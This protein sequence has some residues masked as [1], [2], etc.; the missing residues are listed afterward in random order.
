MRTVVDFH[1]HSKYARATSP[2]LGVEGLAYGAKLKGIDVIGTGDFTHPLWLKELKSKLNDLK[3]GL[4]EYD[5]AKFML[6][7]EVN[8]VFKQGE[9]VRKIHTVIAVSSFSEAEAINEELSKYGDLKA[10]GRPTLNMT[11]EEMLEKVMEVSDAFIVPAHVWTPWFSTF[12]SRFG[13]NSVKEI[14][15]SSEKYI[16][17][18]ETGLSSDPAMNWMISDLDKYSLVSNSDAHSIDKLGREANVFDLQEVSFSSIVDAV[19]TRKGFVKT[20]EFYPH[21]GK[22]YYDGHRKCNI[23]LSPE[24]S[25]QYNNHC[26]ICHKKITV[27]VLHR[28]Y[29]LADRPYGYK[30][31]N[32]VPFQYIIPIKEVLHYLGFRGKRLEQRYAALISY[33]GNEFNIFEASDEQI[34]L[35]DKELADALIKVKK[36]QVYWRPG[37]DG[38]FGEFSF[39]KIEHKKPKQKLLNEWQQ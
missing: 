32:A 30:P 19:K 11:A 8:T 36:G 18:L 2:K 5:G 28:V 16:S 15:G 22:Y 9:K 26:P 33:F 38:V 12:G 10:D 25:E 24:E 20:Y 29:S 31:K 7:T 6:S 37:Y 35:A 1:L 34:R 14:F 3:N 17:A 21:E 39:E 27:G 4:F 13:G 23:Y